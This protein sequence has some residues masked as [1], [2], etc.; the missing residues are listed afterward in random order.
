MGVWTLRASRVGGDDG[1]RDSARER[2]LVHRVGGR[3]S[4]VRRGDRL[5]GARAGDARRASGDAHASLL[6]GGAGERGAR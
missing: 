2:E 5:T 3:G 6:R 1:C 4:V